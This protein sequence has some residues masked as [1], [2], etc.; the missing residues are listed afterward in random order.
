VSSRRD[1]KRLL[2]DS[3]QLRAVR[4]VKSAESFDQQ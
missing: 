1:L 4:R 2:K 3:Q